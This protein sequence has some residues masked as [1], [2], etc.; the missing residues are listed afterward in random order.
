MMTTKE[1]ARVVTFDGYTNNW[2]KCRRKFLAI[3][4]KKSKKGKIRK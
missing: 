3:A 4:T 1:K 2:H